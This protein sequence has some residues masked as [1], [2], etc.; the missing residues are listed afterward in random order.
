MKRYNKA[1]I[2]YETEDCINY[3]LL[4][5]HSKDLDEL[6]YYIQKVMETRKVYKYKIHSVEEITEGEAILLKELDKGEN[7][8]GEN[9]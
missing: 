5:K 6:K 8:N 9:K 7:N 4:L 3:M 2:S 1:L